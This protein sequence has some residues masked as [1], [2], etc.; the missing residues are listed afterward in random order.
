[1]DLVYMSAVE[2]RKLFESGELSPVEVARETLKQID[3]VD[4]RINAF[5]TVTREL[6]LEQARAAEALYRSDDPTPP[7]A[8]IPYSLKDLTLTKGIRTT[9]GSLLYKDWIPAEDAPVAERLREAGGVLLGKTNTPAL[10]W[11]G[12]SGNRVSGPTHNPWKPGRTAGGSSGGAAAAVVS[13][14]GPLAQGSDGAG[15]IRIPAAFSGAFGFK[16][17]WG[18]VP[19]YPPSAVEVLSHVGPITRTV[20]DAALMMAVLAGSDP[21]DRTTLDNEVDFTDAVEGGIE[22]LK[23]GWSLDLGYVPVAPDVENLCRL[24]VRRF[25]E[26][27][28]SVELFEPGLDDPFDDI[29]SVIWASAFA[30]LHLDDLDDVRPQLDPGLL[31]VIEEGA[32]YSAAQLAAAFQR[33]NSYYD[34]WRVIM[35]K[36]HLVLTPTLPITAFEAGADYPPTLNGDPTSYLGWT[37]FTYPFNITGQPAATVPVGFDREGLPVG[38]QIVGRWR[39][40]EAVLRAAAAFERL[41][42]WNRLKPEFA[43]E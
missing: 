15:S 34:G 29:L 22:G 16:P 13:G 40:D 11:K 36:F 6:A 2:L 17:S 14:M 3:R 20:A 43:T 41:V 18:R 39:A 31:E 8:G 12:D 24:A 27:G 21:R 9:R 7:L 35:K 5:V 19:Q 4:P 10:G 23:V 32:S 38:L 30:G 33:R 26:L 42:P 28:C 25:E 37:K 1:L